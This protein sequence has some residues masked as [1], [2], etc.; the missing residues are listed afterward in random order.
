MPPPVV[1]FWN[2]AMY[3]EDMLFVENDF[4]RYSFGNT[5]DGL[6]LAD[7]GSLSILIQNEPP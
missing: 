2:M 4:R 7:D 3:A 6:K 1:T 5:T